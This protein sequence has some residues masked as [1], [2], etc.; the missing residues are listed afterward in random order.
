VA[1]SKYRPEGFQDVNIYFVLGVGQADT[2]VTF[3]AQAFGAKERFAMRDPDGRLAHGEFTVG[4]SVIEIGESAGDWHSRVS[5]HYF[6]PDV[7]ATHAKAVAAGGKEL[8]A[9][10][11]HDSGERSSSVED[12]VGN[13]WFIAKAL[14]G[15]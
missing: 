8:G 6:V 1:S 13:H 10:V 5:L 9:P 12:P 3:L 11:D 2:L 7:D 4:D 15:R 14:E